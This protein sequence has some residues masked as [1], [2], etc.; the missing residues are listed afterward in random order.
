MKP[1]SPPPSELVAQSEASAMITDQEPVEN[2]ECDP[3][4][5]VAENESSEQSQESM[6][7]EVDVKMN[8]D[9][10]ET[11]GSVTD[12]NETDQKPEEQST[13]VPEVSE[14]PQSK[15]SFPSSTSE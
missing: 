1:P 15:E 10:S 12:A 9:S 13:S 2:K 5:P 4:P 3:I 14:P 11:G 7:T 8:Q 6:N